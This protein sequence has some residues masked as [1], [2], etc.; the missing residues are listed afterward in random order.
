RLDV[1]CRHQVGEI[2]VAADYAERFPRV[3]AA[4]LAENV[5]EVTVVGQV[6]GPAVC[7][8]PD[9]T[10]FHLQGSHIVPP[11]FVAS[12]A[13]SPPPGSANPTPTNKNDDSSPATKVRCP[14]CHNPIRLGETHSDE[15]LCPGCGSS[16]RL[17]DAKYT[18]TPSGMKNMGKF[19][20][21]ERIGLGGFGAVWKARDTQLDRIVALKIPHT[22]LLT[23]AEELERFQREAR[24]AAQLR[25]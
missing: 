16:F 15:V 24:A 1:E 3:E 2:P 8:V 6:A 11:D 5:E 19:Q 13:D 21:L 9:K 12:Q 10:V 14:D 22:G 25:H 18:D 4:W 20:L 7:A 17:R 23:D